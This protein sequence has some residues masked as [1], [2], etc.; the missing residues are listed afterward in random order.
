[1]DEDSRNKIASYIDERMGRFRFPSL[2]PRLTRAWKFLN[3][4]I[5]TWGVQSLSER[6]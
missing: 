5:E 1:V 2:N 4:L 6:K 3:R